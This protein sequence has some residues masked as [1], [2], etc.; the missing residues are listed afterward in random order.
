MFMPVV[1]VYEALQKNIVGGV[2]TTF[3]IIRPFKFSEVVDYITPFPAP[4]AVMFTIVK[5]DTFN[6]WPADVKKVIEDMK[7]EHSEWAGNHAYNEGLGGLAHAIEHGVKK[8]TIAPDEREKML[9]TLKPL[10][11]DWLKENKAK[12]LPADQWLDEFNR[13]MVKYNAEY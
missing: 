4:A 1:E 10:T 2:Y 11:Q 8:T 7:M 6:A 3:E 12:G 13:L 9:A 5:T